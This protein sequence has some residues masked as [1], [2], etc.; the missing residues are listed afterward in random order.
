MRV[1]KSLLAET[2]KVR[3]VKSFL[4]LLLNFKIILGTFYLVIGS[5]SISNSAFGQVRPRSGKHCLQHKY[6]FCLC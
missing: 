2:E 6:H 3:K 5:T 4:S 1:F